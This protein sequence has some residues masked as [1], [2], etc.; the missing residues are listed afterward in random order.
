MELGD[1]DG[2]RAI[3][4]AAMEDQLDIVKVLL[5]AGAN[6]NV[7]NKKGQTALHVAIVGGFKRII[8]ILLEKGAN[9]SAQVCSI[10]LDVALHDLL[11]LF[12]PEKMNIDQS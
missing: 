10:S 1:K 4:L 6:I 7:K 11:R 5:E 2:D 3:H 9:S 12:R 8:K